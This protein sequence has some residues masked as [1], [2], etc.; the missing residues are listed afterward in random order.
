MVVGA[1]A[2]VGAIIAGAPAVVEEV[3]LVVMIAGALAVVVEAVLA[4]V[5]EAVL[6]VMTDGAP[7]VLEEA[8]G[9]PTAAEVVIVGVPVEEAAEVIG[10]LEVAVSLAVETEWPTLVLV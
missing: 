5:V 3:V 10:A 9:V 8:V 4:V 6:A 2:A 1:P 7:A